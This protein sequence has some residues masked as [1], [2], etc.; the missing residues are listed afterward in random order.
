MSGPSGRPSEKAWGTTSLADGFATC[1]NPG[2][3]ERVRAPCHPGQH[4]PRPL[5][6]PRHI[7]GVASNARNR[8]A[9]FRGTRGLPQVSS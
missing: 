1:S 6:Q 8:I 3:G 4:D 9:G 2:L 7:T 5:G